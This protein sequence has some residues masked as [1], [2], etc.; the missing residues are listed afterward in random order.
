MQVMQSKSHYCTFNGDDIVPSGPCYGSIHSL[1]LEQHLPSTECFFSFGDE[2]NLRPSGQRNLR[3]QLW[4][5]YV[6]LVLSS[7]SFGE[8]I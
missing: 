6:G 8:S 3:N 2:S 1:D 7:W 5:N 4:N